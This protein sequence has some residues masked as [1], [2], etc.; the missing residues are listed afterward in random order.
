MNAQLLDLAKSSA[1]SVAW[2]WVQMW[3]NWCR[4]AAATSGWVIA[5]LNNTQKCSCLT[6]KEGMDFLLKV[7]EHQS[8]RELWSQVFMRRQFWDLTDFTF[9]AVPHCLHQACGNCRH[10]PQELS[11]SSLAGM[12]SLGEARLT[13]GTLSIRGFSPY[14]SVRISG[15]YVQFSVFIKTQISYPSP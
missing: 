11:T 10:P 7:H 5:I 13:D 3:R 14:K 2:I 9:L 6:A 15:C 4:G 8:R 1:Q 12:D